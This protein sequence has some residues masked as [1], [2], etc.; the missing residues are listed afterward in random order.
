M[1]RKKRRGRKN[2]PIVI[3]LHPLTLTDKRKAELVST[4]L[5]L[6]LS[7]GAFLIPLL[8]STRYSYPFEFPKVIALFVLTSVTTTLFLIQIVLSRRK[9]TVQAPIINMLIIFLF[10][11]IIST[12]F[13]LS[14]I[15]SISGIHGKWTMSL[16]SIT[17]F[18][19]ISVISA[20][21]FKNKSSL[22]I[23]SWLIAFSGLAVSIAVILPL[24]I[25][26]ERAAD[27]GYSPSS[28][29]GFPSYLAI[30]LTLVIPV[31]F[32]LL[33]KY[34][35]STWS[36]LI[37]GMLGIQL[38]TIVLTGSKGS[39]I[40]LLAILCS[41]LYYLYGSYSKFIN[42]KKLLILGGIALVAVLAILQIPPV[43][44]AASDRWEN[45]T[46]STSVTTLASEW[47]VALKVFGAMPVTGTGPELLQGP[48]LKYHDYTSISPVPPVYTRNIYLHI[49]ATTGLVGFI[50]FI[51]LAGSIPVSIF[52]NIS[53]FKPIE[54]G[55]A[56]GAVTWL[57]QGF[58]HYPT[59]TSLL[60]GSIMIGV[61]AY[62][63]R[64]PTLKQRSRPPTSKFLPAAI[65]VFGILL[66]V[67]I[68][69]I[70]KAEALFTQSY[71][72][73]NGD[74]VK[75]GT[76]A[77]KY[78]PNEPAY[79]RQHVSKLI[80]FLKLNKDKPNRNNVIL[81]IKN[82]YR[83]AIA[84]NPQDIS[85]YK[86]SVYA[87]KNLSQIYPDEGYY[88]LAIEYSKLIIEMS[89]NDP[90][91][92]DDLGTLYSTGGNYEKAIAQFDRAIEIDPEFWSGYLHRADL[93]IEKEE[94]QK[95]KDDLETITQNCPDGLFVMIATKM[96]STLNAIEN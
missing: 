91:N 53:K 7:A 74:A 12:I 51:M 3:R 55:F 80:E 46:I 13:S 47:S 16:I 84:L 30:F 92:H 9:N 90:R 24:E 19:L 64:G 41:F 5:Y 36:A 83:M 63:T 79:Y 94:Y 86:T 72:L 62:V 39:W 42:F 34:R 26:L 44:K 61:T 67:S 78:N 37:A 77:I 71:S 68:S 56:A 35:K 22:N 58:Y 45:S 50:P 89:P 49:L 15:I 10:S 54:F 6:S 27:F 43:K 18:V 65:A 11:Y 82:E 21:T 1:T 70:E 4:A 87:L 29:Q 76:E 8:F 33:M 52:R 40:A 25:F 93:M 38:I 66:L 31:T 28:T 60:L 95:A 75:K 32:S 2:K 69:R 23:L 96:L 17:C 88:R 59:I 48:S 85:N 81:Q 20:N 57:V 73:I 14:P